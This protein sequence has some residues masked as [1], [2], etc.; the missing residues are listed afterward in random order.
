[1]ETSSNEASGGEIGMARPCDGGGLRRNFVRELNEGRL[2]F[3]R[4][5]VVHEGKAL[6]I[7]SPKNRTRQRR[8]ARA[9]LLCFLQEEEDGHGSWRSATAQGKE[10]S[11]WPG[12]SVSR[13]RG[14]YG[15]KGQVEPAAG[16]GLRERERWA[17]CGWASAGSLCFFCFLNNTEKEKR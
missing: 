7:E 9:G 10:G 4:D 11:G 2:G 12:R 13:P 1:M 5:I 6:G 16:T 8:H 17:W 3:Y 15:P 14:S